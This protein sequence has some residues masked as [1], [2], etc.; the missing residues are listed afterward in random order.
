MIQAVSTSK[1]TF[2]TKNGKRQGITPGMTVTFTGENVALIVKA[3]LVTSSLTQWEVVNPEAIVP[4]SVGDI[5]SSHPAQ[6][7][8]WALNPEES[9]DR[10]ISDLAYKV[11]SSWIIKTAATRG[12]SEA[13]TEAVP[14][15]GVRGGVALDI[16]YERFFTPQFSYDVGIRYEREVLS[17]TNASLITQRMMLLGDFMYHFTPFRQFYESRLFLGLGLGWGQSST[18]LDGIVQSGTGAVIP[19]TKIGL[20]IPLHQKW[21]MLIEIAHES[22]RT[23]EKREDGVLQETTQSNLRFAVGLKK[24]F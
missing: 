14:T 8:L 7:Y 1:K 24:F 13:T 16:L 23:K 21:D 15:D 10:Y 19:S 9:R 11:R 5:I 3:K 17:L 22:L 2:V 18:A 4:F 12:L 6:E 20:S